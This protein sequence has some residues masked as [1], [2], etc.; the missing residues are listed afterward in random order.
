MLNAWYFVSQFSY[1]SH[2]SQFSPCLL[3]SFSVWV[4]RKQM[5]SHKI[6]ELSKSYQVF[7]DKVSF[8]LKIWTYYWPPL[9]E[10]PDSMNFDLLRYS[11]YEGS[12][13]ISVRMRIRP[14]SSLEKNVSV[15]SNRN[16]SS[17]W[18]IDLY[19]RYLI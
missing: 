15:C 10:S 16:V 18:L 3:F 7:F 5:T 13:G 19:K 12:L 6:D 4:S 8:I 9:F 1:S 2:G 14:I 17:I 11:T